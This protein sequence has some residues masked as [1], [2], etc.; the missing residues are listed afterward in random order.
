[1]QQVVLFHN[2]PPH[3]NGY[4]VILPQPILFSSP[5]YIDP[6]SYIYTYGLQFKEGK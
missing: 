5:N 1:M 2:S 6:T 3:Y 4:T